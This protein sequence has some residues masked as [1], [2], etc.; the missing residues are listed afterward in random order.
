MR[1]TNKD[2]WEGLTRIVVRDED[3]RIA[4]RDK[5]GKCPIWHAINRVMP[6]FTV[7]VNRTTIQLF[8]AK[9]N[10]GMYGRLPWQAVQRGEVWDFHFYMEPN[11]FD[12]EFGI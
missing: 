9:G 11:S 10:K 6:G 5:G 1:T 3:I 2:L 8:P 7:K 12:I 4:K